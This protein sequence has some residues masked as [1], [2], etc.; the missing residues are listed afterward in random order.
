MR[1]LAGG[2]PGLH[3]RSCRRWVGGQCPARDRTSWGGRGASRA[4]S[5]L[6]AAW[7]PPFPWRRLGRVR[8][9]WRSFGLAA[10]HGPCHATSMGVLQSFKISLHPSSHGRTQW[11]WPLQSAPPTPSCAHRRGAR[12]GLL[13]GTAPCLDLLDL[14]TLGSWNCPH[15]PRSRSAGPPRVSSESRLRAGPPGSPRPGLVAAGCHQWLDEHVLPR[16]N[17]GAVTGLS[18]MRVRQS[19]ED[20]HPTPA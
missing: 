16:L 18:T 6:R 8:A 3:G 11:A 12:D 14:W 4:P 2:G 7:G 10:T 1:K 15:R 17:H 5:H 13:G 9:K 19:W 20:A